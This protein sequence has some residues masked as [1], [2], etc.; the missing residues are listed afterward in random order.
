MYNLQSADHKDNLNQRPSGAAVSGLRA[1]SEEDCENPLTKKLMTDQQFL[2]TETTEPTTL[3]RVPSTSSTASAA[4]RA[5][6]ALRRTSEII[7]DAASGGGKAD[8]D[9]VDHP[10]IRDVLEE[11]THAEDYEELLEDDIDR[12]RH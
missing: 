12:S 8:E 4:S 3:S 6:T 7:I 5:L 11:M 10:E 1:L 9:H 2:S